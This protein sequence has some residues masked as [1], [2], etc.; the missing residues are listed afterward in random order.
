MMAEIIKQNAAILEY[1]ASIDAKW[2]YFTPNWIEETFG[3]RVSISR[4][5]TDILVTVIK[6]DI[7]LK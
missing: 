2:S 6:P 3:N 7:F 1:G 5:Q 4:I